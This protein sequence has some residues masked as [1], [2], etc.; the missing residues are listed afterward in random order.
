MSLGSIYESC[1]KD[2]IAITCYM[3]AIQEIKLVENHPDKAFPFMGLGSVF[4]HIDEP[5]WALRCYLQAREIRETRLGGD[6]VDT[7]TVY[8]NLGC[9]MYMLERN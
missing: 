6:T 7:A 5:A 8:N 3:K 9:C 1:G 2:D 4:F